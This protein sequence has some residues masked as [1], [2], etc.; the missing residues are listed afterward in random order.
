[1][2]T[3]NGDGTFQPNYQKQQVTFDICPVCNNVFVPDRMRPQQTCSRKC[4]AQLSVRTK[5]QE[6]VEIICQGCNKPFLLPRH[7]IGKR[8]HCSKPCQYRR[9]KYKCEMCGKEREVTPTQTA[10]RFCGDECRLQWFSE[11]FKGE[12]SPHWKGGSTLTYGANWKTQ[13]RL[14]RKA[15]G[16]K[17]QHCGISQDD[18]PERLSV[19]HIIPFRTFGIERY[20]E[21]NDLSN[22]LALCRQCHI[23]FDWNNGTR[24]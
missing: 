20:E 18:L 23:K 12:S 19:A 16:Y 8:I 2:R 17:C 4:S 21:A 5:G 10:K 9:V 15:A 1:M 11:K 22:L 6:R 3:R 14:A 7:L 24:S 13:R